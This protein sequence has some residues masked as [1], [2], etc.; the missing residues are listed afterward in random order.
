[1]YAGGRL[2]LYLTS[3][4]RRVGVSLFGAEVF[5]FREGSCAR[6]SAAMSIRAPLMFGPRERDQSRIEKRI[7]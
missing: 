1:M 2:E 4:E 5:G 7:F 6:R 3:R